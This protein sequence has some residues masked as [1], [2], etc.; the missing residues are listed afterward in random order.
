MY[1]FGSSKF[2]R[3]FKKL[4]IVFCKIGYDFFLNLEKAWIRIH[5][6]PKELDT[7]PNIDYTDPQH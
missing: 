3:I 7:V 5:I 1:G 6:L 2:K 4:E